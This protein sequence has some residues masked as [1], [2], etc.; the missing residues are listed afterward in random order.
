MNLALSSRMRRFFST[1]PI[2]DP[3]RSLSGRARVVLEEFARQPQ[4]SLDVGC[5]TMKLGQVGIDLSRHGAADIVADVNHL[6][7]RDA[8][9]ERVFFLEVLEHLP[10]GSEAAALDELARVLT[11]NGELIL[12]TPH[13]A[14]RYTYT[15]PAYYLR[16]HRHYRR[17]ALA[18]FLNGAGLQVERMI[19]RGG[20]WNLVFLLWYYLL[21]FTVGARIPGWLFAQQDA[22]YSVEHP[23]GYCLMVKARKPACTA[24]AVPGE[25]RHAV[26]GPPRA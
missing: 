1:K 26:A 13:H 18:R 7:L 14:Y 16:G 10:P 4:N 12:T 6:P 20:A 23:H 11:P 25:A 9:F 19:I 17:E 5:K 24:A 22:N 21:T 3:L 8:S 15:D 2:R